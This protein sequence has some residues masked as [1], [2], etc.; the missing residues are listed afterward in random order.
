MKSRSFHLLAL[1]AFSSISQPE[2]GANSAFPLALLAFPSIQ[3]AKNPGRFQV[4]IGVFLCVSEFPGRQKFQVDFRSN[5]AF[6]LAL[7]AFSCIQVATNSGR[8]QVEFGVSSA[9]LVFSPTIPL[10]NSG[11]K[12]KSHIEVQSRAFPRFWP[13]SRSLPVAKRGPSRISQKNARVIGNCKRNSNSSERVKFPGFFVW[14]RV[15][16]EFRQKHVRVIG[17]CK[18]ITQ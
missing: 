16:P 10:P 18:K 11:R 17:N 14:K 3:V 15:L 9:L 12:S 1:L 4:E 7:L 2:F 6:S 13:Q 5:S 8:F